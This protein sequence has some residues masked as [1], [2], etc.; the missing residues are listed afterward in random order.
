MAH[1]LNQDYRSAIPQWM[2]DG[3]F[4]I[5]THWGIYCVPACGY[6]VSWYP[7]NMYRPGSQQYKYHCEH[8]GPPE[9]FGYKD[10]IP[11]F[12]GENFDAEAWAELFAKSGAKF[13]GPVGEHHDGFS[14]WDSQVNPWN[15]AKMG[16]HRDVVKELEAAI[17]GRG[18]KYMVALHH[19]EN[20]K[21]FPH[22]VKEYDT[23]DPKYAGLYGPAHNTD[24]DKDCEGFQI[25]AGDETA[26]RWDTQD[27]PSKEF[28]DLWLAKTA[29]ITDNYTPDMIWFDFGIT[30]IPE[31]YKRAFL[32]HY[33]EAAAKK[34]I[35]PLVTYKDFDM[36][37]GSGMVDLEQG[38][39]NDVTYMEWLTDST[40]DTGAAWGYMHNAQYRSAQS[41]LHHLIDNVSKNGCLLLNVAPDATGKFPDEVVKTLTEMGE[42]LSI[43]GEAIYGT[44]PWI[45][46]G[47]G[48]NSSKGKDFTDDRKRAA[49]TNE[50][51][52]FTL[53]GSTIYAIVMGW[54]DGQT[55]VRNL[56]PNFYP[57][58]IE[59]ISM[60]GS[61]EPIKWSVQNNDLILSRPE[62]KP[63][64]HAFVYKIQ[65]ND[66]SQR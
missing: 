56:P 6:N 18:M 40:I 3:K 33:F 59:N 10:F 25:W 30:Y 61:S 46:C 19:A 60:L 4:G 5:Y 7:Y 29:E 15:S 57:C 27:K 20:W 38:S 66:L 37:F 62:K 21:F 23:S 17:R 55:V 48:P 16:P 8:F 58:E 1:T 34:G 43:N 22:W 53:K 35:E 65:R 45:M 54:P 51:I 47:Q 11:M 52:R 2:L 49:F 28:L 39:F 41:L 42:W 12:T 36:P 50:D 44:R 32:R 14:M 64:D 13:A 24:W 63:C 26:L 9:K 31:S